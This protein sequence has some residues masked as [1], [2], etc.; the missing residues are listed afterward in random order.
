MHFSG[1]S[2]TPWTLPPGAAGASPTPPPSYASTLALFLVGSAAENTQLSPCITLNIW[3]IIKKKNYE[4]NDGNSCG[5][6]YND[7]SAG[8]GKFTDCLN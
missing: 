3:M 1:H 5:P 8:S 4:E 2:P 6:L 7:L